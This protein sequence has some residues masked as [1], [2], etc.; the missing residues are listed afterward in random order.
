MKLERI[1]QLR[2]MAAEESNH[3]WW[4]L[5]IALSK[6]LDEIER[7]HGLLNEDAPEKIWDVWSKTR[8]VFSDEDGSQTAHLSKLFKVKEKA[9]DGV[10]SLRATIR[11]GEG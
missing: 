9:I 1:E 5:R 8:E 7:L 2:R 10:D 11:G 4:A 3:P 6:C